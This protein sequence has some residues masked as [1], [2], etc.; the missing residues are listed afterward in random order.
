MLIWLIRHG[1][2]EYNKEKRYQGQTDVPLSAEG[3]AA[4]KRAHF[5]PEL[6]Y[7]SPLSRA[8]ETADIIFPESPKVR[9]EDIKEMNFGIFEGRNYMEMETDPDY[10]KWIDS[11]GRMQCPGGE[12]REEFS[13]RANSALDVLIKETLD[14]GRNSLVVVTHGG[15]IMAWMEAHIP[16]EKTYWEWLPDNAGGYL[17]EYSIKDGKPEIILRETL[18]FKL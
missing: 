9:V 12:S 17:L 14:T 8:V 2:T 10:R 3:R 18:D 5:D 7:T 16:S 15:I 1:E 13:R 11:E 4:I 6:V